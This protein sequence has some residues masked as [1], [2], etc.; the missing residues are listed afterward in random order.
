MRSTLT[1]FFSRS[2][3]LSGMRGMGLGSFSDCGARALR[4][5]GGQINNFVSVYFVSK[6]TKHHFVEARVTFM[7]VHLFEPA[8]TMTISSEER[9]FFVALGE[10]I[11]SLRR[12]NNYHPGAIG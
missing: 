12:A 3:S 2:I 4:R 1:S 11:A 10:R 5:T 7:A 8:A 9:A 6:Y